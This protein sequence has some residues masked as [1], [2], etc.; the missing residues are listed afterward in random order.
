MKMQKDGEEKLGSA[1]FALYKQENT[2]VSG[3]VKNKVAIPGFEDMVTDSTGTVYICG[4]NS[5]RYLTPGATGSV[6]FLEEI[7]APFNYKQMTDDIIFRLSPVG[8]P[9][10]ISDQGDGR[11]IETADCYI[12]TLSVPNEKEDP[13][14][15][16]LTVEKKVEGIF[17]NKGREFN[18]TLKLS[19]VPNGANIKWAK[20]GERQS[21][22]TINTTMTIPFTM[23]HNDKIEVA[24]P[25][26]VSVTLTEENE[27]YAPTIRLGEETVNSNTTTFV[28]A[29]S[30][31]VTVTN[32]L[33]GIIATGILS[34]FGTALILFFTPMLPI[35][36]ILIGKR[37]RRH[38]A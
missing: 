16:T 32:R 2:A 7:Q 36:V 14:L 21:D 37:K 15:K 30:Q 20:N 22:P 24:L 17:G 11:L 10:I 31:S 18:F 27:E 13:N 25:V 29:D 12:Y 33:D 38:S 1:H 28:F 3:L 5:D 23:K 4:G 9:S 35:G 26:G 6:Y 8:V 19:D 34:S